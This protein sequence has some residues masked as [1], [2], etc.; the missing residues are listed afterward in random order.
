MRKIELKEE[1]G[2]LNRRR[3]IRKPKER[4]CH[5]IKAFPMP[6]SGKLSQK[7]QVLYDGRVVWADSNGWNDFSAHGPA[8]SKRSDFGAVQGTRTV[9][10]GEFCGSWTPSQSPKKSGFPE[11]ARCEQR[12]YSSRL[13]APQ[14]NP[15]CYESRTS[16]A[17]LVMLA[18]D[19]SSQWK[20]CFKYKI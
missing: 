16:A 5:E 12:L 6:G 8:P 10:R 4:A 11:S 7:P 9:W 3:R 15:F 17:E 20:C 14:K 18:S 19:G 1:I 13:W 2:R